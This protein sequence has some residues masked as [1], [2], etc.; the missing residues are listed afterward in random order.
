M[1]SRNFYLY[2]KSKPE[3]SVILLPFTSSPT[4]RKKMSNSPQG[5]RLPNPPGP[6]S[7]LI[8]LLLGGD[9]KEYLAQ[10]PQPLNDAIHNRHDLEV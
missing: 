4:I 5:R 8:C 2:P 6:L 1:F 7:R 10:K 9:S 3:W